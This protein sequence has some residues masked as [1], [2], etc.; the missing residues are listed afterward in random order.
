VPTGPSRRGAAFT[1]IE[2]MVT[3]AVIALVM[4]VIFRF[5]E[6]LLPETRL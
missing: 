3:M 5:S 6:A 4:A 1:L 2:L